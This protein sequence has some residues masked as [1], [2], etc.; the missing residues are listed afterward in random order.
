MK[1]NKRTL[2]EIETES[3]TLGFGGTPVIDNKL[4]NMICSNLRE[5]CLKRNVVD[6][7]EIL[8]FYILE[9]KLFDIRDKTY[10]EDSGILIR[11]DIKKKLLRFVLEDGGVHNIKIDSLDDLE[12][13]FDVFETG[14]PN[15]FFCTCAVY[16]NEL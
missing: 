14:D 12:P 2:F 6:L 4:C 11:Y 5:A 13:F 10:C 1:T 15:I 3:L 7:H 16:R 9:V 8:T